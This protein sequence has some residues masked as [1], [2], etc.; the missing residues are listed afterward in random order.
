MNLQVNRIIHG[1]FRLLLTALI[2]ANIVRLLMSHEHVM[3]DLY[4]KNHT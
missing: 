3:C 2:H 1:H 4:H